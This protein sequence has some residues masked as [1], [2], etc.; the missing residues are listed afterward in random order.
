MQQLC[1]TGARQLRCVIVC[2]F[3]AC[4]DNI[5]APRNAAV[6]LTT[7]HP[8]AELLLKSELFIFLYTLFLGFSLL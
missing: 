6:L 3:S 5:R 1:A 8:T 2:V 4:S 7:R